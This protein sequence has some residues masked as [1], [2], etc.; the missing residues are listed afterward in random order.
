LSADHKRAMEKLNEAIQAKMDV[1]ERLL[2]SFTDVLN[3]KKRKI[4]ELTEEVDRLRNKSGSS[5]AESVDVD[6]LPQSSVVEKKASGKKAATRSKNAQQGSDED[7]DE[8]KERYEQKRQEN[9][10]RGPNLNDVPL[11]LTHDSGDEGKEKGGDPEEADG[12]GKEDDA[13]FV[14]NKRQR[15]AGRGRG[16]RKQQSATTSTATRSKQAATAT[17]SISPNQSLDLNSP[18]QTRSSTGNSMNLLS[19][20]T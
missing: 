4:V 11:I 6:E 8:E 18:R 1:E 12:S 13:L 2:G 9:K 10:K 20:L 14:P 19:K 3:A 17:S 15:R 16:G 7:T 5:P